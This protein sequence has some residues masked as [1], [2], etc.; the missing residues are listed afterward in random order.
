MLRTAAYV[1]RSDSAL[2][3]LI[4]QMHGD[5]DTQSGRMGRFEVPPPPPPGFP[6]GSESFDGLPILGELDDAIAVCLWR[7]LR[8]ARLFAATPRQ[9]LES[10]FAPLSASVRER[11]AVALTYAPELTKSLGTFLSLHGNGDLLPASM[12][13]EACTEIAAWAEARGM[14]WTAI[15]FAEAA[16][17][18]EPE[19]PRYALLAGVIARKMAL[20]D[21]APVWHSRAYVLARSKRVRRVMV[22]ALL[23]HGA[24]H[25]DVG[26]TV[27][28]EKMFRRAVHR[29]LQ[30]GPRPLAASACH[31]LMCL[32]SELGRLKEA[33]VYAW[34]AINL[35]SVKSG[36]I[37]YLA[38]DLAYHLLRA[39]LYAQAAEILEAARDL[40]SRPGDRV[41]A[42]STFTW[43][44]AH[45]PTASISAAGESETL[46][47]LGWAGEFEAA[48]MLHLAYA[49][50]ARGDLKRASVFAARAFSAAAKRADV[51]L[52]REAE[53]LLQRL[54]AGEPAPPPVRPNRDELALIGV[55][56][57]RLRHTRRLRSI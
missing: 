19:D 32:Y 23:G 15:S 49:A 11:T 34:K 7:C 57:R 8:D 3:T 25:K 56:K 48:V 4:V 29:A 14:M 2:A 37:P 9:S 16:A 39:R 41:L 45:T 51:L 6:G 54:V 1:A 22:E 53:E 24:W 52:E 18:C 5:D 46:A 40:F 33:E 17:H 28:A 10:A 35:Y 44:V 30:R 43:A 55:F 20:H 21:R 47:L 31:H 13:A 38:H 12:L 36:R 27:E 50:H 42:W 26:N